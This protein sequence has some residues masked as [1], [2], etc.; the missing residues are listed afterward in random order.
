MTDMARVLRLVAGSGFLMKDN[1]ILNRPSKVE[2]AS[3]E[4]YY[5]INKKPF[6]LNKRLMHALKLENAIR[7]D[8]TQAFKAIQAIAI[9]NPVSKKRDFVS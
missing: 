5:E 3:K 1:E 4:M 8:F 9:V 7:S 6:I 2:T